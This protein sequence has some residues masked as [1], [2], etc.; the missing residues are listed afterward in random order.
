MRLDLFINFFLIIQKGNLLLNIHVH[1]NIH[2]FHV[3]P[4][5]SKRFSRIK[6]YILQGTIYSKFAVLISCG[7]LFSFSGL[8][9]VPFYWSFLWFFISF[10]VLGFSLSLFPFLI[11]LI[12]SLFLFCLFS[13]VFSLVFRLSAS[14]SS[15]IRFYILE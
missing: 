15:I 3:C 11:S 6:T 10:L 14:L 8:F 4:C 5:I 1:T 2:V 9:L 12:F 13:L 7:N